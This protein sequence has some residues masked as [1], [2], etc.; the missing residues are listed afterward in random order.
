MA[1]VRRN[2]NPGETLG[3]EGQRSDMMKKRGGR[4]LAPPDPLERE[5]QRARA[6]RRAD[7]VGHLALSKCVIV[8]APQNVGTALRGAFYNVDTQTQAPRVPNFEWPSNDKTPLH[9]YREHTGSASH[10]KAG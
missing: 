7:A 2:T 1:H 8:V 5:A 9:A 10:T 6:P 4:W 3:S